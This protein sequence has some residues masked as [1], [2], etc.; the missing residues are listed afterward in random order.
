MFW[1]GCTG[2]LASVG[3]GGVGCAGV[4]GCG[5]C[6]RVLCVVLLCGGTWWVLVCL[7]T[8]VVDAFVSSCFCRVFIIYLLVLVGCLFLFVI[9]SNLSFDTFDLQSVG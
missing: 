3:C 5:R 9:Y 6:W 7:N 8:L 4:C 1:C 2:V